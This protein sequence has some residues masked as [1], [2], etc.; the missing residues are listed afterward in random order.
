MICF[1]HT[2]NTIALCKCVIT[3]RLT[4]TTPECSR[5]VAVTVRSAD[6]KG[7]AIS[8]QENVRIRDYFSKPKEFREQNSFVNTAL[9]N[10]HTNSKQV[11]HGT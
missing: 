3:V 6:L 2:L 7:S 5:T 4:T 8:S 11:R 9:D 1:L 10:A